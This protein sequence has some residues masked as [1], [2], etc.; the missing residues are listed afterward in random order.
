MRSLHPK[1][2]KYREAV[3]PS[4]SFI[5][6]LKILIMNMKKLLLIVLPAIALLIIAYFLFFMQKKALDTELPEAENQNSDA[7]IIG[8]VGF[9]NCEEACDQYLDKCLSLVPNTNPGLIEDG[10]KSC[11]EECE[12]WDINKT[13]CIA[14][15]INCE[16]M[17]NYCG[18]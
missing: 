9:N 12:K 8:N 18:L 11:M 2:Y 17:T 14:N 3:N 4:L 16:A 15:A 7:L 1:G 10:K 5:E 6:N 13:T